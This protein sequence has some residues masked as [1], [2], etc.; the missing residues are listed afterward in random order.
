MFC[1]VSNTQRGINVSSAK[2][3]EVPPAAVPLMATRW[4]IQENSGSKPS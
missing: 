1:T 2:K 4:V 3:R